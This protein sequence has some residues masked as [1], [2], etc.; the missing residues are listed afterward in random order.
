MAIARRQG[1]GRSILL[2]DFNECTLQ[3]AADELTG[4]GHR[5]YTQTVDVDSGEPRPATPAG[6]ARSGQPDVANIATGEQASIL[7]GR[8]YCCHDRVL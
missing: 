2:A 8:R 5:V 3:S 4:L 7:S 6:T 1:T